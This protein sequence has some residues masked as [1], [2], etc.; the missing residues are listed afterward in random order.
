MQQRLGLFN[1]DRLQAFMR[2]R[3]GTTVLFLATHSTVSQCHRIRSLN[4][5]SYTHGRLTS[6]LT[7]IRGFVTEPQTGYKNRTMP[8]VRGRTLGGSS[9]FN[10]MVYQRPTIGTLQK[11][12]DE[13]G[14]DSWTWS[15][16]LKYYARSATF[17]PPTPGSRPANATPGYDTSVFANGPVQASYSPFSFPVSGWLLKASQALG[18]P[19]LSS[20][21]E[22]GRLLGNSWAPASISPKTGERSSSEQ[23]YLQLGLETQQLTVYTHS[24]AKK[25]LFNGITA[26]GVQVQ[27][28]SLPFTL[29]AKKE[30]IVS[31]GAFQS[32]Q[33]RIPISSRLL[34]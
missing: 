17:T 21:F 26:T 22:S 32:P 7:G 18:I 3:M 30:V 11:W 8:Y 34:C 20:G 13:V 14:D 1:S 6:I 12:G 28:G 24:L 31:C 5:E 23:A 2:S 27:T 29:T 33:V 25:I 4:G 9:A 15:N 16:V 19:Y 10:Y